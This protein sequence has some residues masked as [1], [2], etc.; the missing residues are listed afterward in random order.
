[1]SRS[2]WGAWG[3]SDG[4]RRVSE[5][6]LD[7]DTSA[8]HSALVPPGVLHHRVTAAL[9]NWQLDD[10]EELLADVEREPS[11][12]VAVEPADGAATDAPM[13]LGKAWAD[14]LRAELLVRR[15]RIAGFTLV[16]DPVTAESSSEEALDLH[17]GVA[18]LIEG[19]GS[20][21]G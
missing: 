7:T 17:A 8:M 19:G 1:V 18:D 13:S 2:A 12:Y 16:G 3:Q 11:P 20:A 21:R 6:V 9:A 14:T 15:L 10:A 5:Q 4:G